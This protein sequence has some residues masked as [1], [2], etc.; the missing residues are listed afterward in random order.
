MNHLISKIQFKEYISIGLFTWGG[1]K[2]AS[3][4]YKKFGFEAVK[5]MELKKYMKNF[6]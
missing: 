6:C 3:E 5:G 1:N 4:F 2:T